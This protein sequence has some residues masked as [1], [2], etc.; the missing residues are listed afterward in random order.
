LGNDQYNHIEIYNHQNGKVISNN[1][2]TTN[3]SIVNPQMILQI[4]MFLPSIYNKVTITQ[5]GQR[6]KILLLKIFKQAQSELIQHNNK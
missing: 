1:I 5:I 6:K 2:H 4:M 3:I